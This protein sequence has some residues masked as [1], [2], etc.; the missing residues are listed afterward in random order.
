MADRLGAMR[1]P[2]KS[3]SDVIL[4]IA[5]AD[6]GATSGQDNQGNRRRLATAASSG[7]IT[8]SFRSRS[9]WAG[10]S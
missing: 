5:G 4:R 6:A 1:E 9:N 2:G 7:P 10:L 3:Y 8:R